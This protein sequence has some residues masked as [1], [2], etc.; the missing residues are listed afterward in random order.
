MKSSRQSTPGDFYLTVHQLPR[1]GVA[2]SFR[3]IRTKLLFSSPDRELKTILVTS[4]LPQE[5]KTFSA[6]GMGIVM[7]QTGKRVLLVDADKRRPSLGKAFSLGSQAENLGLSSL[8]M[9]R[10]PAESVIFKTSIEN[11]SVL[12]A[13]PKPPNPSELLSSQ[14]MKETLEKLRSE[15]DMLIIDTPPILGLPDTLSLASMVD[16]CLFVIRYSKTSYKSILRAKEAIRMV[17]GRIL[18]AILNMVKPEPFGYYYGGYHGY[19]YHKYYEG[20]G[21]SKPS[22]V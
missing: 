11:L 5:G 4:T 7:A 14:S 9:K 2:E 20:E 12:P 21:Q 3:N 8:V 6:I 16:G 18:G 19:Y 17:K 10:V 13:G 22:E 1:S 15:F